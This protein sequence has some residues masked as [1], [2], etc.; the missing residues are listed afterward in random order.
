MRLTIQVLLTLL[1][2]TATAHAQPPQ[3]QERQIAPQDALVSPEV[4]ADRTVTFRIWAPNASEISVIGDWSGEYPD[5]NTPLEKGADGIWSATLGPLTPNNYLYYFNVDGMTIADPVNPIIKLRARSSA[6]LVLVPGGEPWEFQDVPHG[7][8]EIN[9]HKSKVLDGA[10]RAV[11]VYLPPGYRDSGTR[12]PILYLLHGSGDV[13]AGWTFT[14]N[15]NYIL[16]NL[17]A[18]KRA[19]PMVVVMTNGHAIPIGAGSPVGAGNSEMFERYLLEE[20]VPMVEGKYRIARGRQN[21]AIVGLSMGGGQ[22]RQ[23]GF[24]HLDMFASIGI[25]SA[26]GLNVDSLPEEF[27]DNPERANERLRLL[28]LGVGVNDSRHEDMK[29]SSE[30]L[31]ARGIRNV[32]YETE[33]GHVWPVWRRCLVETASRLFQ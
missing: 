19:V 2:I 33:L 13:A 25:F 4:Y 27:I 17:I 14:G 12:Y 24:G 29:Q 20:V 10:S 30:E 16:D 11:Y 21:R 1:L 7:S 22:A 3:A 31:T 8:V 6:S 18:E 28:F 26:G 9:W 23:I 15:A 5:N 32:Y